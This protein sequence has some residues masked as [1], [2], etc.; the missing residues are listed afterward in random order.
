MQHLTTFIKY[1]NNLLLSRISFRW[2]LDFKND[3]VV[4]LLDYN[5][6]TIIFV[7]FVLLLVATFYYFLSVKRNKNANHKVKVIYKLLKFGLAFFGLV[8]L[9]SVAGGVIAS[10]KIASPKDPSLGVSVISRDNPVI[11]EFDRPIKKSSLKYSIAPEVKGNWIIKQNYITGQSKLI[12]VP[13]DTL[14]LDTRYTV[15]AEGIQN[16][17]SQ[18]NNY[19]FSFQTPPKPTVIAVTPPDGDDGIAP[20]QEIIV[21]TKDYYLDYFQNEQVLLDFEISPAVPLEKIFLGD[22]K[23]SLKPK[24]NFQKGTQYTFTVNS[25]IYQRD[26]AASVNTELEA[27]KEVWRSTFTITQASGVKKYSP[28]GSNVMPDTSIRIE[29]KQ[30]MDVTSAEAAFSIEPKIEGSFY[31]EGNRVI[32]FRPNVSMTKNTKHTVK[33]SNQAK[34]WDGKNM[35][36]ALSFSFSTI[37]YVTISSVSPVNNAKNVLISSKIKIVFNQPVDHNSA[38]KNIS[39]N[40]GID[41]SFSWSNNTLE[42]VPKSLS[43]NQKYQINLAAGIITVYGLDSNQNFAYSFTTQ[44]QSISLAV[45]S[46]KQSHMYSCMATA[47]RSALAFKGVLASEDSILS[48]IGYDTTTWSGSWNEAGSTWGDPDIGIVGDI[49]GKANNIGWGYGSYWNPVV[50]AI[51]SYGKTADLKSGWSVQGVAS[52]ISAGNPIIVWWVNGV[53]PAY[54]LTWYK[55]GK[56]IRAVNSMHVQTV[57]G[58]TGTVDNPLSF[59]VTDSGYGYPSQTFD[60]ASFKAKWSWFNNTA[61]VVK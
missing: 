16:I 40:P 10:P 29:F 53:W 23:F 60:T 12:F 31:W 6:L 28:M 13:T 45:P 42:F 8:I 37:G 7:F 9:F 41:G 18:K 5:T 11:L 44:N 15:L 36:E 30:D 35:E 47:A 17:F 55:N 51:G 14:L 58:F 21:Q 19:M 26:Y 2:F 56:K 54:E 20:D 52:E 59:T 38:E 4:F 24:E 3:L 49:D 1:L 50:N 48:R 34:T 57:K 22:N 32:T 25:T 39:F 46:Y 43:Y 33:I 27:E 61:I